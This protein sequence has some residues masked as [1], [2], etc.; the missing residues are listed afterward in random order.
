[1]DLLWSVFTRSHQSGK[2]VIHITRFYYLFLGGIPFRKGFVIMNFTTP[3][4]SVR[5]TSPSAVQCDLLP[6]DHVYGMMVVN[7]LSTVIGTIGNVLVIA[8]VPTTFS[9]QT[10]SNYWLVSMAIADLSV[11]ALGQPLFSVWLGLQTGGE[12]DE[13]V[14]Q[15]FRLIANMSCAASVMHLGFISVD[16]C[17]LIL[18]PHDFRAIRTK[19]RFKIALTI[20]WSVPVIYAVLR[21][22]VSREGTSYFGVIAVA[23]NYLVIITCYALIVLKIRK[24]GSATLT[25]RNSESPSG[26]TMAS[27]HTVER[28]VTITIAIVII[29]FTI[30]W[31]PL[32]YLR[33]ANAE[34]GLTYNWARTLAL[35]NSSMNPWIYC[36]RITEFREAYKRLL[37][38]QLR[39]AYKVDS[40][41]EQEMNTPVTRRSNEFDGSQEDPNDENTV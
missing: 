8:T 19:K 13:I 20:A 35:S 3:N 24:Q 41:D 28:R 36:F 5:G 22:T 40:G 17:L 16:R 21:L 31:F 11:T 14:S 12:C 2:R 38:C 10:I 15:A 4:N 37:R 29:I 27:D 7:L 1:M 33:S 6:M 30:C 32:V 34:K 39:P 25:R 26:R 18:R 9:L 23:L